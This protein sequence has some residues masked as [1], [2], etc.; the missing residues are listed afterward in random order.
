MQVAT[1]NEHELD[2]LFLIYYAPATGNWI[3]SGALL[4]VPAVCRDWGEMRRLGVAL[5]AGENPAY[6]PLWHTK[7]GPPWTQTSSYTP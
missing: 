6:Q 2:R 1:T 7:E 4:P 3:L 5:E